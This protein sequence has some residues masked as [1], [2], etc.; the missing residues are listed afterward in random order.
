MTALE[1]ALKDCYGAKVRRR[2]GSIRFA[3][4]L[5]HMVAHDGLT[6]GKVP[7]NERCGRASV[8]VGRLTGDLKPSLAEIRNSLAHG[9]PFDSGPMGGLLE[10]AR[11][12][13]LRLPRFHFARNFC[14]RQRVAHIAMPAI[15][16]IVC[17]APADED[18][19]AATTAAEI[20]KHFIVCA[21]KPKYGS[22]SVR[23]YLS[24]SYHHRSASGQC[25]GLGTV[26]LPN[27]AT[28]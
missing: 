10:L 2:N 25:R 12:H 3:D 28:C 21:E 23:L 26:L 13:R 9:D 14:M 11:P 16:T 20:S 18:S 5:R 8:V 27:A 19:I 6:D 1:L 7:M 17:S 22:M 15:I 24:L 4:L